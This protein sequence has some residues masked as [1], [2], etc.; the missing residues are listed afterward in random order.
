MKLFKLYPPQVAHMAETVPVYSSG[1]HSLAAFFENPKLTGRER[2]SEQ[3][4]SMQNTAGCF[5]PSIS[6]HFSAV[7]FHIFSFGGVRV[8]IIRK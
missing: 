2:M 3:P 4:T 7:N 8:S 6:S 1:K 5:K